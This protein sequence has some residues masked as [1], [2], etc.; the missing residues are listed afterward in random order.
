MRNHGGEQVLLGGVRLDR[1]PAGAPA[2]F[3]MPLRTPTRIRAIAPL[4]L[5]WLALGLGWLALGLGWLAALA[6]LA[7]APAE[8][9][10]SL[11]WSAPKGIDGA[12]ALT[13]VSCATSRLCVA[14]DERGHALVSTDPEAGLEA[15][16]TPLEID[17]TTALTGIS[18]ASVALCVAVD[19]EGEAIVSTTP[20][21]TSSA[22]WKTR[23]PID[24]GR[25]LSGVS[26]PSSALCVAVDGKGH[27]IV[28]TEPGTG[29]GATWSPAQEI[30]GTSALTGVS[31]AS[32]EVCV[33]I[34]GEGDALLSSQPTAGP[35]T[36][37]PRPID[38]S[39]GLDA[40]ACVP[41]PATLCMA[42][43][44]SGSAFASANPEKGS[45][46]TWSSTGGI[47]TFGVPRA[48]G[49]AA[50]GLCVV[51]DS[52]GRAFASDNLTT[53][54]PVWPEASLG[55]PNKGFTGISC[56]SAGLCAGVGGEGQVLVARVPA[57]AVANGTPTGVGETAAT[58]T[59]TVNPQDATL[60]SC[61]FEYGTSEAYGQSV[62]CVTPL[63][64]EGTAPQTVSAPVSGLG[65]NATYHYRLVGANASGEAVT[66]DATF[67]TSA[68]AL[69]QPHPSIGGLPA[70]GQ[71]LT[72]KSGVTAS[73]ASAATLTYAWLRNTKA[74]SGARGSTYVV[75]SADVSQHLQCRVTATNAAG[76]VS[77]SS[78]FVTVPAGGL[79]TISE[80][81]VGSPSVAGATV[82][83]PLT[84]SRQAA[85]G[86]TISLRLTVL[87][88]LRG[89]HVIA[90]AAAHTR[91]ATVT[92][93][94][95][96]VRLAPAQKRTVT[97]TLSSTGRHL[98]AHMR[99]MAVRLSV[100]GTVVGAI[101]ASLKSATLTLRAGGNASSRKASRRHLPVHTPSTRRDS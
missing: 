56:V 18:C 1:S 34:D 24:S 60:T 57:P 81:S 92:L 9:T 27:A 43:D 31:C 19:A 90:V 62:P 88:T 61:R 7:P 51:V 32:D 98:L 84:C 67:K 46:A 41:A 14:V 54:I 53:G 91:R 82:S 70:L 38:P 39:H 49:C 30:D 8:A 87:E 50:T 68:P 77:A 11:S 2:H 71:R 101:S 58:L 97:L 12:I 35:S 73:Q 47:D 78:S 10:P 93:A 79:G 21:V 15:V 100:S 72:C 85:G 83:V 29:V 75:S 25:A 5:G 23:F 64:A 65:T 6:F 17:G 59:G 42:V 37:H 80:S 63:P 40:I 36:W 48:V 52:A 69:V 76:S 13:G 96:T 3:S 26:C 86:C 89:N 66:T 22:S 44:S 74:I 28:G 94:A 95:S 33:A 4:G 55:P 16:W 99:R 45:G 20:T